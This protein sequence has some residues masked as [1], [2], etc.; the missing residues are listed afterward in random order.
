MPESRLRIALIGSRDLEKETGNERYIK[1][2]YNVA[3]SFAR[4]GITFTSGLAALGMDA[5]AQKAYSAAVTDGS[6]RLEQFEVY[7]ANQ[8]EIN[9]SRLPNK[10][11]S[12][13]MNQA[14]INEIEQIAASIHPAWHNCNEWAR[15]MH[16]RNVHQILGYNLDYPVDA[17][18]K[19]VKEDAYGNP[20][21]GNA[22]AIKLAREYG[23]PVF[24]LNTPDVQKVL[25]EIKD[26][27]EV[28]NT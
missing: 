11:L 19:W 8:N 27:L 3:Y 2:C 16:M 28:N 26:W 23:I 15:G 12:I 7:V 1:L 14:K 22:T 18:V 4:L 5:I 25:Y 17:V 6:A 20:K 21:G 10:N 9:K 24:N 13:I